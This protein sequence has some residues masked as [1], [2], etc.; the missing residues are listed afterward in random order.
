MLFI[1]Q[2]EIFRTSTQIDACSFQEASKNVISAFLLT[3]QKL[4]ARNIAFFFLPK[5]TNRPKENLGA[6][7]ELSGHVSGLQPLLS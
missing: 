7:P 5:N 1:S 3:S 2:T 6:C 4:L